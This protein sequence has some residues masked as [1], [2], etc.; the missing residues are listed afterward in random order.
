MTGWRL[1]WAIGNKHLIGALGALKENIDSGQFEA[2]Q[3]TAA[4][5]LKNH[6]R[7]I[8]RIR[9][10]FKNRRDSFSAF[11]KKAG[12]KVFDSDAAFFI[13]AKPPVKMDSRDCALKIFKDTGVL[14][15]PGF[16][17]GK[18][19]AFYMRFSLTSDEKA[20]KKAGI[21]ISKIKW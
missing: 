6:K 19:G 4:Y 10:I 1:G 2:I 8:P 16:G 11:L 13:W 9:K 7:F 3:N 21:K 5:A 20:L 18:E 12:W 17:F 15:S 14:S